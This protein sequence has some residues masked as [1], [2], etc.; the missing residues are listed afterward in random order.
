M[1]TPLSNVNS[2]MRLWS[3]NHVLCEYDCVAW[4]VRKEKENN[5][6][7]YRGEDEERECERIKCKFDLSLIF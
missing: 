4:P 6:L 3:S 1:N 7:L 2:L 5:M